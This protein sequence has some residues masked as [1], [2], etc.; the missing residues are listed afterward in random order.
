MIDAGALEPDGGFVLNELFTSLE[1]NFLDHL[2]LTHYDADHMGGL[3]TIHQSE[4]LLWD[5]NCGIKN[6]FPINSVVDLGFSNKETL[7]VSQYL[8]CMEKNEVYLSDDRVVIHSASDVGHAINLGGGLSAVVVAG[9]GYVWGQD[10]RVA[11]VNTDNEKSLA[12]LLSDAKGNDFLILGDLTGT[13][14][15]Q[16]D[17]LMEKA[18]GAALIQENVQVEM[19]RV[20]HH[21]S[22]TSST[23]KFLSNL[24]PL[25][26]FVSVGENSFG[27]PHCGAVT[28]LAESSDVVFYTGNIAQGLECEV[29]GEVYDDLGTIHINVKE[30]GFMVEN[31][32]DNIFFKEKIK[33]DFR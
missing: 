22:A 12:V 16:E 25:A 8:D 11:G 18:L 26:S 21:G 15:G 3:V 27:H 5:E 30:A 31:N 10:K 28:N 6:Y 20:G 17:A 2:I 1:L 7:S 32:I 13:S 19:L 9:N 29:V 4:S 14:F 23:Q 24:S 33:I